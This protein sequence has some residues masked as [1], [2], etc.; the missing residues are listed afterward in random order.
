[1]LQRMA[2]QLLY[3]VGAPDDDPGLRPAEQLVAGEADEIRAGSEACARSRLVAEVHECTGAQIVQER[4]VVTMGNVCQLAQRRL[5]SEAD[6]TEVGLMHAQQD[7]RLGSD[8][9]FIVG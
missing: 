8:R 6:D 2:T 3:E 5:R 9:R 7:R 4:Q 1:P